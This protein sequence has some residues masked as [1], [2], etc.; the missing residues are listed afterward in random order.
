VGRYNAISDRATLADYKRDPIGSTDIVLNFEHVL[1]CIKNVEIFKRVN[2]F[3]SFLPKQRRVF[4]LRSFPMRPEMPKSPEYSVASA[5]TGGE[6]A[7]LLLREDIVA[8]E[9]P[10]GQKLKVE[11]LKN[12]YRLSVGPLREAMSRLA[13]EFLIVQEGQ[14]GFRVAQISAQDAR[15]LGDMRLMVEAEALRQSIPN[16]DTAWEEKIITTFFRLEQIETGAKRGPQTLMEWERLNEAF[17]HALAAACSSQWLMRTR[18]AMFRHHE[19]YRRLSRI[20]TKLTR[21]IHSEHKALMTAALDRDVEKAV[22]LIRN[23]VEKTTCAVADAI[24]ASLADASAA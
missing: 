18:E 12:R 4:M 15:E 22:R 1:S 14:R 10:P 20:K 23:H 11:M 13:A 9:L 5:R 21:D 19:R 3:S 6:K 7:Y 24:E 2:I 16:G 17:H 8:G